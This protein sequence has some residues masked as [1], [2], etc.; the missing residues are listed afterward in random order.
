MK[1]FV[2]MAND[3]PEG[4]MDDEAKAEELVKAR[5]D[6]DKIACGEAS[7]QQIRGRIYWRSYPFE[8]N[9]VGQ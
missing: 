2:I 4:V 3:F 5:N 8:L 1:L 7:R 6:A 9:K